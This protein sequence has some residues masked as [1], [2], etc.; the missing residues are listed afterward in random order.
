[1]I[2]CPLY[3][4]SQISPKVHP[5]DNFPLPII[6]TFMIPLTQSGSPLNQPT[7]VSLLIPTCTREETINGGHGLPVHQN[8]NPIHP[9]TQNPPSQFLKCPPQINLLQPEPD[10]EADPDLLRVN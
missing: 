2:P 9:F 8:P 5:P 7:L 10:P 1:M 4:E 6:T 3:K